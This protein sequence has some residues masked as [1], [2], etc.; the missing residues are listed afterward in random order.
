MSVDPIFPL[1]A[2]L[3]S[4]RHIVLGGGSDLIQTIL[5][6]PKNLETTGRSSEY[7]SAVVNIL[8]GDAHFSEL[9]SAT[10]E[11][12]TNIVYPNGVILNSKVGHGISSYK[13]R[14]SVT[15]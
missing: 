12:W 13:E 11:Y 7:V 8:E 15:H 4:D 3:F 1:L 14:E 9:S 6:V 2:G 5:G 10:N